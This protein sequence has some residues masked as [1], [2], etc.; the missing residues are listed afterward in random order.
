MLR[1]KRGLDFHE[2][3]AGTVLAK[4]GSMS[5]TYYLELNGN[6]SCVSNVHPLGHPGW[7]CLHGSHKEAQEAALLVWRDHPDCV[8]AIKPGPCPRSDDDYEYYDRYEDR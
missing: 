1:M 8:I 4:D 7:V 3:S 5:R 2:S 6:P